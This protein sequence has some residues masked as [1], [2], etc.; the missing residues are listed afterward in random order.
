M[1]EA[2]EVLASGLQM[3][4]YGLESVFDPCESVQYFLENSGGLVVSRDVLT[5]GPYG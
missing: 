5:W 1:V 4:L 2:K 3:F